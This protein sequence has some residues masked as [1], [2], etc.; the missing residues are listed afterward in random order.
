MKILTP[1]RMVAAASVCVAALSFGVAYAN[2]SS[3][4]A[5]SRARSKE[6]RRALGRRRRDL[7]HLREREP[8][9]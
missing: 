9:V 3:S 2:T 4:D 1:S 7:P 5:P 6:D 8:E